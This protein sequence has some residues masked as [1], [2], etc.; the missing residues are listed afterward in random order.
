MKK[1]NR[2]NLPKD[3]TEF[4]TLISSK[5]GLT[6]R[7]KD[8]QKEVNKKVYYKYRDSYLPPMVKG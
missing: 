5:D 1:C 8:C 4:Y 6:P 3:E 2:C 7:C